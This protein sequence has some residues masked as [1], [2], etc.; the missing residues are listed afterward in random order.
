MRILTEADVARLPQAAIQAAM[1]RA[2]THPDLYQ[3][4]PRVHLPA[5]AG[6]AFLAMPCADAD[7]YFAVKQVSVLPDAPAHGR[8]SVQAWLTLMGPD[9]APLLATPAGL[10]TKLRTSAVSAVAADALAPRDARTLTL[11]GTG[12]LAPHLARAHAL[13]RGITRIL[14]WGRRPD[15]AAALAAAL[16]AE[17]LPGV[18]VAP[19]LEA[20]VRAGD[21]ISVA[22]TAR[23]PLVRGAWLRGGQHVDLVGAFTHDMRES[24]AEAIRRSIVVVD[25]RAAAAAEAGDLAFATREGWAWSDVAGDLSDAVAGRVSVDPARPTLFKSVGLPLEDLVIARLLATV[26]AFRP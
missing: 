2:F 26:V 9:G 20:A 7:G 15:R 23:E 11:I 13:V 22:T 12:A 16:S 10:L 17:G 5:P 14:V 6:G 3:S 18:A 8:E 19:D 24:D 1:R 25:D 21:V 4:A